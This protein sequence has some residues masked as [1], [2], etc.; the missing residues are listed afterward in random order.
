MDIL[1]KHYTERMP[2]VYLFSGIY[3]TKNKDIETTS[4]PCNQILLSHHQPFGMMKV[5]IKLRMMINLTINWQHDRKGYGQ[6]HRF[7]DPPLERLNDN[8]YIA[9]LPSMIIRIERFTQQQKNVGK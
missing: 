4:Q 3:D 2:C 6:I 1:Q 5:T 7:D 9:M 8:M